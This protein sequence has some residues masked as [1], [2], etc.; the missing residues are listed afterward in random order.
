MRMSAPASRA[1]VP[2]RNSVPRFVESIFVAS[3]MVLL[4]VPLAG[5]DCCA[6]RQ[7]SWGVQITGG[8]PGAFRVPRDV[9]DEVSG[10]VALRNRDCARAWVAVPTHDIER[11][12]VDH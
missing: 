10:D 7:H 2:A 1:A 9:L 5:H 8:V 6:R 4:L 12:E 11:T 3:C